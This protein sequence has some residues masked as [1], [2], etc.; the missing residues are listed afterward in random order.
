VGNNEG[1]A[2]GVALP[3]TFVKATKPPHLGS[4]KTVTK[5][6]ME[7][8]PERFRIEWGIALLFGKIAPRKRKLP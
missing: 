2:K 5:F 7:I 4:T 1:S 8:E 6:I 3:G